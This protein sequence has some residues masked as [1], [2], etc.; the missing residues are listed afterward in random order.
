MIKSLSQIEE[1]SP[2]IIL[3]KAAPPALKKCGYM[4]LAA[5]PGISGTLLMER[6]DQSGQ[7]VSFAFPYRLKPGRKSRARGPLC[8]IVAP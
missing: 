6:V 8:L 7:E 4:G 3:M 1:I 2:I 5:L